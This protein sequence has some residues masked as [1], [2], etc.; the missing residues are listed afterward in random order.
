MGSQL[1]QIITRCDAEVAEENSE[2]QE[3]LLLPV[4]EVLNQLVVRIR[5]GFGHL[6]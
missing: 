1:L 6:Y 2:S 5:H 3:F 4:L